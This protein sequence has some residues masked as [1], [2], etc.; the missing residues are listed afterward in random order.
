MGVNQFGT[1]S[2]ESEGLDLQ[3][4]IMKYNDLKDEEPVKI[5]K[6]KELVKESIKNNEKILVWCTFINSIKKIETELREWLE[7]NGNAPAIRIWGEV[8]TD[9]EK[10]DEWNREDEIEKFKHSS[11]HNVLIANPASLSES[12]SLHKQCHH[13]VYL[14]R[15][16]NCGNY[17]QSLERIHRIG[18]E[19]NQDTKY[20]ILM[21]ED[22][23]DSRI[24]RNLEIKYKRMQ[25]FLNEDQFGVLNLDLHF[26][27]LADNDTEEAIEFRN[28][29]DL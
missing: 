9:S 19:K 21:S 27:M 28:A 11:E 8:P 4:I 12:I 14:D 26:D 20:S 3:Q 25:D 17:I 5:K 24:D 7:A 13:A 2:I 16:Y 22:T 15:T 6:V 29:L 18:L 10:N 23:I 1:D